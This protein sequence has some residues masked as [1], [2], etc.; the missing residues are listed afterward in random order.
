MPARRKTVIA[1]IAAA[2]LALTGAVAVNAAASADNDATQRPSTAA[3][4]VV[5]NCNGGQL[6]N[7]QSRS[8]A[9]P[10]SFAST[11]G[12]PGALVVP[13]TAIKFTGPISGTDTLL[14]TFSAEARYTGP[15]WL[16]LE[17]Y[18][19]GAEIQPYALNGSPLAF[20]GTQNGLTIGNYSSYATQFCGKIGPGAH[21]LVLKAN[22]PG[23][24][25]ETGWLDDYTLSVLRFN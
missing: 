6:I 19:D 8:S 25:G 12:I 2:A 22:T 4:A 7:M 24:T 14:L 21:R 5:T 10:F 16:G 11:G 13:G 1:L 9:V 20:A 18:I 15:N 3:K 23:A 17:A